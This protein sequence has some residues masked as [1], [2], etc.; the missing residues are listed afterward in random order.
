MPSN[1]VTHILTP[2]TL[3]IRLQP[4]INISHSY[5]SINDELSI[6]S[7]GITVR[8][9]LGCTGTHPFE[10]RMI[11]SANSAHFSVASN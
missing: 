4:D 7:N 6:E 2:H 3:K 10:S 9:Q 1:P 8:L 5:N 11:S